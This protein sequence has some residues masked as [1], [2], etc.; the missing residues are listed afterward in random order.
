MCSKGQWMRIVYI[1]DESDDKENRFNGIWSL[2]LLQ[3]RQNWLSCWFHGLTVIVD[4]WI[5]LIGIILSLSPQS[6]ALSS[7]IVPLGRRRGRGVRGY[8]GGRRGRDENGRAVRDTA[9]RPWYKS[10]NSLNMTVT[11][12]IL[13]VSETPGNQRVLTEVK[14]SQNSHGS[15]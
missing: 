6:Q 5:T 8:Y 9:C 10:E 4:S 13:S 1:N 14:W 7:V 12:G 15:S 3:R 11:V 2:K